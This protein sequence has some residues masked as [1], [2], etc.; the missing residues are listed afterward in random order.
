MEIL[1]KE[2]EFDLL[3]AKQESWVT[4]GER[5]TVVVIG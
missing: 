4:R 5:G 1:E 2:E 3:V